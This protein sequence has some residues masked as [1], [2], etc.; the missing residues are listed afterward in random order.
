MIVVQTG[1]EGYTNPAKLV[2]M[3]LKRKQPTMRRGSKIYCLSCRRNGT[4]LLHWYLYWVIAE[5]R[6]DRI[7]Q[8]KVAQFCMSR[9]Y[10]PRPIRANYWSSSKDCVLVFLFFVKWRKIYFLK[11]VPIPWMCVLPAVWK[12]KQL[13]FAIASF[14]WLPGWNAILISIIHQFYSQTT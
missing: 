9:K 6:D 10:P 12:Q 3:M 7:F 14:V 11:I 8:L 4:T 13:Q 1:E 5:A 2:K